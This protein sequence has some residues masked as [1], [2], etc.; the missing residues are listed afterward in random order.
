MDKEAKIHELKEKVKKFCEE[1]D[2]DQFHNIKDL[3]L[4][5]SIETSELLELFRW[6][7]PQEVEE[8]LKNKKGDIEDEL[9]LKIKN[10][11]FNWKW[12]LDE[13]HY[14]DLYE[15]I[16]DELDEGVDKLDFK[17]ALKILKKDT[18]FLKYANG[19]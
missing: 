10:S 1:R 14:S 18:D 13:K 5:L 11:K 8:V 2:W 17:K 12:E 15:N 6:K 9:A 4:A 3:A 19:E 16:S 7:N